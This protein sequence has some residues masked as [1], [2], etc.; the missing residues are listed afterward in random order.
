MKNLLKLT[1]S[2]T[3]G[4]CMLEV[5]LRFFW[6]V[7]VTAKGAFFRRDEVAD[8]THYP[9]GVGRMKTHEFD[10]VLR[11][12]N[13]GMRDDDV[14]IPKPTGTKRILVIGDSFMEGWGC[15]RDEIFTDILETRLKEKDENYEVVAAGVASW[16][17]LPEFAWLKYEGMKLEPDMVIFALDTTDPV[18]DSFYAHRLVRD[19]DGKPD[20]IKRSERGMLDPPL[21]LHNVLSKHLYTYRYLDRFL[22]KKFKKTEWDHGYWADD[23]WIPSRSEEDVPAKKYDDYWSHTK[24]AFLAS[25]DLL[26][27]NDISWFVFMYPTGAE[28]DTSAWMGVGPD[29]TTTGRATAGFPDGLIYERRFDYFSEWAD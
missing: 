17:A 12:N 13:I 2:I 9:Y 29:G 10:V 5:L 27:K 16:A 6:M 23:V 15:K 28:T 26:N 22:I 20:Y 8:H 25:R 24:E 19:A 7:P 3:L 14:S 18:G 21:W 1:F 11:M 4:L